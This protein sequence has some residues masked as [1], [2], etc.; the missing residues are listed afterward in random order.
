MR[1]QRCIGREANYQPMSMIL[2]LHRMAK[3]RPMMTTRSFGAVRSTAGIRLWVLVGDRWPRN[4]VDLW[5]SLVRVRVVTRWD[6]GAGRGVGPTRTKLPSSCRADNC[7]VPKALAGVLP[8]NPK[9]RA[10]RARATDTLLSLL[11]LLPQSR[12]SQLRVWMDQRRQQALDV[13]FVVTKDIGS[14]TA[15]REL[16]LPTPK[17]PKAVRKVPFGWNPWH[18]HHWLLW[19]WSRLWRTWYM[20]LRAM[21]C[22]TLA[23]QKLWDCWRP[24]NHWW[25]WGARPD[26]R[27]SIACGS[28][29]FR[30]GNGGVQYSSSYVTVPQ[31][32]GDQVVRLGMFTIDA[33]KVPILVGIKTFT[34]LDLWLMW[35]AD[36]WFL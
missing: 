6:K 14:R 8:S 13:S 10:R 4:L 22:S 18:P 30:F 3:L 25:R 11:R 16:P 7:S 29:P 31:R 23:Q 28:Q 27:S 24:W 20:T 26:P 19:G 17:W 35:V 34:K 1:T 5:G 12:C 33:E 2:A 9:A 15:Q 21:A 32:L 36:G